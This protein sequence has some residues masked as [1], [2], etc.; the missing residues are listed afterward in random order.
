M[1]KGTSRPNQ[2]VLFFATSRN[3]P[4]FQQTG[5]KSAD[6]TLSSLLASRGRESS[7]RQFAK[8]DRSA[9]GH[10]TSGTVYVR[11]VPVPG[12][13]ALVGPTLFVPPR[14]T[15]LGRTASAVRRTPGTV[16]V[17]ECALVR[18]DD[19]PRTVSGVSRVLTIHT[20][21]D[22]LVQAWIRWLRHF[23][24]SKE[25][26]KKSSNSRELS[27][28]RPFHQRLKRELRSG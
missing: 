11:R 15:R 24:Y 1:V 18:L 22:T 25:E 17:A 14:Q 20:P 3:I 5:L 9:R 4:L 7:G 19:Q 2:L 21:F 8:G 12:F 26:D 16:L 6:S 13:S 10:A 23:F 28:L 27:V